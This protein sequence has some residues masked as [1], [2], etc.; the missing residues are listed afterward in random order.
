MFGYT[1]LWKLV[2]I[3][4]KEVKLTGSYKVC[5]IFWENMDDCD[6]YTIELVSE[7]T[8]YRRSA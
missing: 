8:R 4:T 3:K 6:C 5:A 2:N 7:E 1:R